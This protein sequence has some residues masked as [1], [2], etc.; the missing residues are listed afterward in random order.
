M[1]Y[2]TVKRWSLRP[3]MRFLLIILIPSAFDNT[4][5]DIPKS[6]RLSSY[7]HSSLWSKWIGDVLELEASSSIFFN[8][9]LHKKETSGYFNQKTLQI[10]FEDSFSWMKKPFSTPS[11]NCFS[12][13]LFVYSLAFMVA[14]GSGVWYTYQPDQTHQIKYLQWGLCPH[15]AWPNLAK[16]GL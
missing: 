10:S 2:L 8:T 12:W 16:G 3:W 11:P 1:S 13:T 4:G 14:V 6:R 9:C 5:P 15:P 7:Y